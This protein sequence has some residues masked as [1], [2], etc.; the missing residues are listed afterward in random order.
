MAFQPPIRPGSLGP[1]GM[2][3]ATSFRGLPRSVSGVINTATP[4]GLALSL[5]GVSQ[6]AN[7][8]LK[9]GA[10][11][12]GALSTRSQSVYHTGLLAPGGQNGNA[13]DVVTAVKDLQ[14]RK[15][16]VMFHAKGTGPALQTR[17]G[18]LATYFFA[19][20]P[21]PGKGVCF[22]P[23][24]TYIMRWGYGSDIKLLSTD[25]GL[26]MVTLVPPSAGAVRY[27]TFN[28]DGSKVAAATDDCKV[29]VWVTSNKFLLAT[30]DVGNEP[31]A[32][33]VFSE[34][35]K[36]LLSCDDEGQLELWSISTANMVRRYETGHISKTCGFSADGESVLSCAG[37]DCGL[38]LLNMRSGVVQ[39]V[40][41]FEEVVE[42]R[43][44]ASYIISPDGT[45]VLLFILEQVYGINV[46]LYDLVADQH[47]PLQVC[48]GAVTHADFS[49][50]SSL[51]LT[52]GR[53]DR[54]HVWD[55]D[56]GML[57]TTLEGHG[58][59]VLFCKIAEDGDV[60]ISGDSEGT[61][62]VWSLTDGSCVMRLQAHNSPV[63][64]VDVSADGTRAITV[65][66]EGHA[67][68]WHLD[69]ARAFEVMRQHSDLVCCVVPAPDGAQLVVGYKDGCLRCW[70]V[71]S[72]PGFEAT[73]TW[74]HSKQAC[75]IEQLAMRPDGTQVASAGRDGS[76]V[77]TDMRRGM[78]VAVLAAHSDFVTGLLYSHRSDLLI[79]ASRVGQVSVWNAKQYGTDALRELEVPDLLEVA[80]LAVSPNQA[81]LAAATAGGTVHVWSMS[82]FEPLVDVKVTDLPATRLGFNS[83]ASVL[84]V[85]AAD[86]SVTL[87]DPLSG[88]RA[89]HYA[90]NASSIN[91]VF[92]LNKPDH[93]LLTLCSR[94]AIMWDC[95]K[96]A[97]Q[98]VADFIADGSRI[99]ASE[100]IGVIQNRT[101]VAHDAVVLYDPVNGASMYDMQPR[102]PEQHPGN[103]YLFR[104][105]TCLT[106]GANGSPLVLYCAP[107]TTVHMLGDETSGT[108][109]LDFS[110]DGRLLVSGTLR[111]EVVVWDVVHQQLMHK[112]TAHKRHAITCVRF[113]HDATAVYS[114]AEDCKVIMWDWRRQ[115]KLATLTGHQS[116]VAAVEMSVDGLQM[117]SGDKD[118]FIFIWDT[119][120]HV[121]KQV[122]PAHDGAVLC[123]SLSPCGTMVASTGA[124]EHIVIL[125]VHTGQQLATLDD[126]MDGKGLTIKFS[127]DGTK[128]LVGGEKGAVLIWDVARNCLLYDISAHDGKVFDCGWSG[129]SRRLLS[130]GSD[131]RARLWDA[132]AGSELCQANFDRIMG[133]V[134]SGG[135]VHCDLSAIGNRMAGCTAK[136]QLI[137]WDVGAELR[138][139][140]EGSMLYQRL[141][142]LNL[143][144]SREVYARL[145]RAFPLLPNT[146][147]SRG[148][149]ILM[150]AVASANPEITKLIIG[151]VP[152][153][154]AKLGLTASAVQNSVLSSI[155]HVPRIEML[156]GPSMLKGA[157]SVV[158]V[159]S[160]TAAAVQD[161][162][163][164][165]RTLSAD[166]TGSTSGAGS[167]KVMPRMSA[168]GQL[169]KPPVTTRS[170]LSKPAAGPEGAGGSDDDEDDDGSEDRPAPP[171]ASLLALTGGQGL[172]A[173]VGAR[174]LAANAAAAAAAAQAQQA[175]LMNRV[176]TFFRSST[177]F[178]SPAR[179]RGERER[180]EPNSAANGSS[181]PNS[182]LR[183]RSS[184]PQPT[185]A[186]AVAEG[187]ASAGDDP[188][189]A[190]GSPRTP[191]R[192]S[193]VAPA[194][195]P[196]LRE[197]PQLP[198]PPS[199]RASEPSPT[200]GRPRALGTRTSILK[201]SARAPS[202]ASTASH[203]SGQDRSSQP[204]TGNQS[205]AS[206]HAG[207]GAA[208]MKGRSLLGSVLDAEKE[209]Q[210][211]S[212]RSRRRSFMFGTPPVISPSPQPAHSSAGTG[213]TSGGGPYNFGRSIRHAVNLFTRVG[214]RGHA[215]TNDVEEGMR[216][217]D[218][219]VMRHVS[220]LSRPGPFDEDHEPPPSNK[221]AGTR[222]MMAKVK[223]GAD[224]ADKGS[225]KIWPEPTA[226]SRREAN[227]IK[228][229]LDVGAADCVQHLLDAVL[230]QKVTPGSY[231]AITSAIP[232][233]ANQYPTMCQSFLTGLPLRPLGEMEVPAHVAA[234]GMIVTSA[235]SYTS[236]KEMWMGELQLHGTN[237]G[238]MA[239]MEACMVRLPF[240]A[241][242]GKS[243]VLHTLVESSVP[244]Q[245]FGSDTVKAIVD[246]KWRNF[247][248]RRI[249]IKA[250]VY[251]IYTLLF[252][253]FAVLFADDDTTAD[254]QELYSTPRGV[255]MV[256]FAAILFLYGLYFTLLECLQLVSLGAAAY[257]DSFWNLVDIA[258]YVTTLVVC[259]CTVFRYGIGPGEF[260]PPLVAAEVIMLWI[261]MLF[262]GLAID[263]VGTFIFMVA[264]II[265][266][267]KYFIGLLLTLFI[268]F[269]VA[270]MVL[271]R[272]EPQ[273]NPDGTEGLGSMYGDF[274]N[275][276]LNVYTFMFSMG[277]PL[278]AA[279]TEYSHFAVFLF[280]CYLFAL[281][282]VL[283]NMLIT[284]M[285]DIYQKVK[286]I[287]HFVFLKGRAELIIDVESTGG[288]ALGDVNS[289]NHPYLHLLMPLRKDS[290]AMAGEVTAQ[291][292]TAA[293]AEA[294]K[295]EK[296]V[297]NALARMNTTNTGAG[298]AGGGGA[299]GVPSRPVS[300][301]GGVPRDGMSGASS[302]DDD[303]RSVIGGRGLISRAASMKSSKSFVMHAAAGA[304]LAGAGALQ[305]RITEAYQSLGSV[306]MARRPGGGGAGGGGFPGFAGGGGGGADAERLERLEKSISK[307]A[308]NVDAIMSAM[309]LRRPSNGG[310]NDA[311]TRHRMTL[312]RP[313]VTG[314]GAVSIAPRARMVRADA[315]TGSG[316]EETRSHVNT[317]AA[318]NQLTLPPGGS[319]FAFG[320]AG[321]MGD[322]RPTSAAPGALAGAA[323][324]TAASTAGPAPPSPP[325]ALKS[326][327]EH[328]PHAHSHLH[329][330]FADE[331]D[332]GVLL[333]S[334]LDPMGAP[335]TSLPGSGSS[336]VPPVARG[337]LANRGGS[338]FGGGSPTLAAIRASAIGGTLGGHT[339]FS[340]PPPLPQVSALATAGSELRGSN[341]GA[342]SA[343]GTRPIT[344][345]RGGILPSASGSGSGAGGGGG[346]PMPIIA[347][348]G[349]SASFALPSSAGRTTRTAAAER[350]MAG[351]A[352]SISLDPLTMDGLTP[353]LS[354]LA[355][356]PPP[357]MRG[358]AD[359]P[360]SAAGAAP[361]E[362]T[363]LEAMA[364]ALA[365]ENSRLEVEAAAGSSAA[366]AATDIDSA[367][368]SAGLVTA[369][370]LVLDPG[371]GRAASMR[372]GPP[373]P[374]GVDVGSESG[375][376]RPPGEVTPQ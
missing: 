65:D 366:T 17:T 137:D 195:A 220:D 171:P 247:A 56:T 182:P 233:V 324:T 342:G 100:S 248:Q 204:G 286:V 362:H 352:D 223:E 320:G 118:G 80:A 325:G 237:K 224:A 205:L 66:N 48:D 175:S 303:G 165:R 4:G 363:E 373:R 266:G 54:I 181:L 250:L 316:L 357:P 158:A 86:G 122:I 375:H 79:S 330:K 321:G 104:H 319:V 276:L 332:A 310:A 47:T 211:G 187:T 74:T 126:A 312:S 75:P 34:D 184:S 302:D 107:D 273:V 98:H 365:A 259:P 295:M 318:S 317:S 13:A 201:S 39:A 341:S 138:C 44:R 287:Q 88:I 116:P 374:S 327:L 227:A 234:R 55:S 114:C 3:G 347:G 36:H 18:S 179:S 265:K 156:S 239:L 53:D 70:D 96:S 125:D 368:P 323:A 139:V 111:G 24:G 215:L 345:E 214:S 228:I 35:N 23:D 93:V 313:S 135:F 350:S 203:L 235:P 194:D 246:Y 28:S 244:V 225:N 360:S 62:L 335:R 198:S 85:G 6:P 101:C 311:A 336:A 353:R 25:D 129:D 297:A 172:Q 50:D 15:R 208:S 49:N 340:Q 144:R 291:S 191:I 270:F 123:C 27:A 154:T 331:L 60:A 5:P 166:A 232:A 91:D 256:V 8:A 301:N 120:S 296:L 221:P 141:S 61:V 89:A 130:V 16:S 308:Q 170:P 162:L 186:G 300:M 46:V 283:L 307:L 245:T 58:S 2:A 338:G 72:G 255:A 176:G 69:S 254:Q 207:G 268:S 90:G 152:G 99:F 278:A 7:P 344:P 155:R 178:M 105:G 282:V 238:P 210:L 242:S 305:R 51:F 31:L 21:T 196:S 241:A 131:G 128:L 108:R 231:H 333:G 167:G 149:T 12:S 212:N 279:G 110:S 67:Y 216:G 102:P 376:A 260:V 159:G 20:N 299:A 77:V 45:K 369:S 356:P 148:F 354:D 349:G 183:P 94:Q 348:A 230:A 14:L 64:Y 22:S 134:E 280:C 40:Q 68:L 193:Q 157:G 119:V 161:R 117:A 83:D 257:F 284:L 63:S 206:T 290:A 322:S 169:N 269:A 43:N 174:S 59:D 180:S 209:R 267:L 188:A 185:M 263:G 168:P 81:Y 97:T 82:R 298:G 271:F 361:D 1:G 217:E 364:H 222:T 289:H 306:T 355:S 57:R 258:A 315:G 151:S 113:T 30:L 52:A 272:N 71:A 127:F 351:A 153:G 293:A 343:A 367:R 109:C 164:S 288:G 32:Y 371:Q 326:A 160:H 103:S 372:P 10:G 189:A 281:L 277:E 106:G 359:A 177:D 304:S 261:K 236:Y 264:E 243:S 190:S 143:T 328:A 251:V 262:Y 87:V 145:L 147:D 115:T 240:A 197:V 252:T 213:A 121:P 274:G 163:T 38:M 334:D 253:I 219:L 218:G 150:H 309:K 358:F 285:A 29:Y 76:I 37:D 26:L 124:D 42:S 41:Q 9:E 136:G 226:P 19:P 33:V 292:A 133:A 84:A 339:S 229:A 202:A 142:S 112:W 173:G 192:A 329:T 140:P 370:R 132:S 199:P 92:F 78:V 314:I 11:A 294:A 275:S 346:G 146:Q 95:H 249:Y 337:G 73:V 200:N